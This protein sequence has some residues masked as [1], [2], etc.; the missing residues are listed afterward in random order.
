MTIMASW[1]HNFPDDPKPKALLEELRREALL[2]NRTGD[3]TNFSSVGLRRIGALYGSTGF[4]HNV[5]SHAEAERVL[6][7]FN[8]FYAHAAPFNALSLHATWERCA[9]T[10]KRC[11]DELEKIR[12]IGIRPTPGKTTLGLP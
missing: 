2:E 9:K 12:N 10:E 5:D 1:M 8:G 3:A 11:S 4:P 7:L 6:A